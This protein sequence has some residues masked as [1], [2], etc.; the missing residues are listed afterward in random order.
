[1]NEKE[2]IKEFVNS[3]NFAIIQ[4]YISN[5]YEET[6]EEM[7]QENDQLKEK[8]NSLRIRIK[9]IKRRRKLQ[10][11]KI[12]KYKKIITNQSNALKNKNEVIEEILNCAY[13]NSDCPYSLIGDGWLQELCDCDNCQNT[14]KECW[15]K[16]FK[17]KCKGD[18]DEL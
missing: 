14:Y 5:P 9:T 1:M 10:S 3:K 6:I 17:N 12:R 13:F 16:Y 18:N 4:D 11:Q 15:L 8:N 7:Q 2:I